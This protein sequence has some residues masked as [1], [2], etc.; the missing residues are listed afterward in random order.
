MWRTHWGCLN[1]PYTD[2]EVACPIFNEIYV[3]FTG[4]R[5]GLEGETTFVG[6]AIVN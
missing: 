4:S 1:N 3:C 5:E 2:S 6:S